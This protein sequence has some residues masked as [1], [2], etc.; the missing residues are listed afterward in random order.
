MVSDLLR[1]IGMCILRQSLSNR[2]RLGIMS[3]K[4]V[5]VRLP[6]HTIC[7]ELSVSVASIL[8]L[9]VVDLQHHM[10]SRSLGISH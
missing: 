4:S 3:E 6:R 10:F 1:T 2:V 9:M 5:G 8:A 7:I